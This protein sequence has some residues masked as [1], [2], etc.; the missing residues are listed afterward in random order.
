MRV[1]VTGAGGFIGRVL[2][3]QLLER[4]HDVVGM[5][6]GPNPTE[7][8][9]W[10][11]VDPD[12]R[13]DTDGLPDGI[14]AV[15]HLAQSPAYR[16]GAAGEEAVFHTNLGL[17]SDLLRWADSSGVEGFVAA[18]TGTVYEPFDGAMHEDARVRPTG[19]YGAS[20]LAAE[21]LADAYRDRIRIAHLR[22]FFVYGPHQSGMLIA[23]LVDSI[24]AGEP[25]KLPAQGPGLEFV[26]TYVDDVAR[27]FVS[28]VENGW[29]GPVNV[30]SPQRVTFQELLETIGQA[31]GRDLVVERAG[32]APSQPI[33]P[34]LTKLASLMDL[35]GFTPLDDGIAATVAAARSQ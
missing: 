13:F 29:E 1:L 5:D 7:A 25:V 9:G 14:N 8:A 31:A 24:L 12:E 23:R 26:P 30:A 34:D 4:G 17:L 21:V 33:V 10:L 15:A 11:R 2:V 20:K 16:L 32:E 19:Y 18:S 3:R 35:S 22:L 6:V 28:A 27:A